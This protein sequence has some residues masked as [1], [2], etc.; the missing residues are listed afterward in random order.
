[1]IRLSSPSAILEGL[2]SPVRFMETILS[3]FSSHSSPCHGGR[4]KLPWLLLS[5]FYSFSHFP[6]EGMDSSPSFFVLAVGRIRN[7]PFP[8]AVCPH[9]VYLA[10]SFWPA[11]T[12][13]SPPPPLFS[14]IS[15]FFCFSFL[16][17][18]VLS[19]L[20]L[21]EGVCS[22]FFSQDAPFFLF[23][24]EERNR[25]FQF[26]LSPPFPLRLLFPFPF[27]SPVRSPGR[28]FFFFLLRSLF[29]SGSAGR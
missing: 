18:R 26:P 14:L 10:F 15:C 28:P 29:L 9:N 16:F 22:F 13:F 17:L 25:L 21:Y 20:L 4:A 6:L 5:Y 19:S 27:F 12:D 24:S 23:F 8:W 2:F 3:P 1:L 7:A 11:A